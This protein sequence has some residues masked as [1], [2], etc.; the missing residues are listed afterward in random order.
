MHGENLKEARWTLGARA[1]CGQP[2]HGPSGT[3][4]LCPRWSCGLGGVH[5]AAKELG[6]Q[7][8]GLGQIWREPKLISFLIFKSPNWPPIS[9]FRKL[10]VISYFCKES[11]YDIRLIE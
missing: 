7:G 11:E 3:H 9:L 8:V 10:H 5:A 2:T 1:V 4:G 6:V